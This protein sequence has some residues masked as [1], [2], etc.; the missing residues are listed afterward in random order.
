MTSE[1]SPKATLSGK[2]PAHNDG[3]TQSERFMQA[4]LELEWDDDPERFKERVKKL[5]ASPAK[6]ISQK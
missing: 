1:K 2:D 6:P 5:A 3:L 4:A